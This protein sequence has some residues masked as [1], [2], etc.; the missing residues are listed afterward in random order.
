MERRNELA[1]VRKAAEVVTRVRNVS[2]E[3]VAAQANATRLVRV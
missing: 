3:V 1:C 2:L